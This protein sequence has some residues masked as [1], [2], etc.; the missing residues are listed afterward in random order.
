MPPLPAALYG[1]V[2]V[3]LFR[4]ESYAVFGFLAEDDLLGLSVPEAEAD[5]WRQERLVG[6]VDKDFFMLVPVIASNRRA[7]HV[8][9]SR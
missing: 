4:V 8:S 7:S 5:T 3:S 6:E 1:L 2:L 9:G